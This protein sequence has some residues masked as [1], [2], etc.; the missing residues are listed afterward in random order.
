VP[1][2]QIVHFFSLER[3]VLHLNKSPAPRVCS[4]NSRIRPKLFCPAGGEVHILNMR[5]IQSLK[6]FALRAKKVRI[7]LEA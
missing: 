3:I 4:E 6:V 1:D 2:S 5:S 7:R